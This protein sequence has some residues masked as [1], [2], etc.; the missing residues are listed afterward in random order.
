MMEAVRTSEMS[1]NSYQFSWCYNPEDS[2]FLA[3]YPTFKKTEMSLTYSQMP[4]LSHPNPDPGFMPNFC[5]IHSDILQSIP[6]SPNR[7]L[8]QDSLTAIL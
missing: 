1:V 8:A 4:T 7:S 2:I 3:K 6:R 5:K